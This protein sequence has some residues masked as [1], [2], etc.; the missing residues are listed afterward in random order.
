MI[1]IIEMIFTVQ[2]P[3]V[4]NIFVKMI[5]VSVVDH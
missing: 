5:V 1:K 3:L 4:L 2:T